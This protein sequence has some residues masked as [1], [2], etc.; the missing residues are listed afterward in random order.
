LSAFPAAPYHPKKL[1][2]K[3]LVGFLFVLIS[4]TS[5]GQTFEANS[6]SL[7]VEVGKQATVL[8]PQDDPMIATLEDLGIKTLP[9]YYALIIGVSEYKY[10]GPRLQSLD[11]PAKDA[12]KLS[13]IL[14]DKY[15]FAREDVKL[16]QNPTAEEIINSFEHL[17]ETVTEKDNVLIFYAGHGSYDQKKGFGYWLPSDAKPDSPS[18]WISNSIIKDYIEAIKS[19]HTLLITDACFSGSIFKSR[20]FDATRKRMTE[21]Y[22]DKSR[23]AMTSGN[24][25]EVPDKSVFIKFLIKTLDENP[26]P[27]IPTSVLFNRMYEPILNNANTTPQFGVVQGA[28]D[29]GGEFLFFKKMK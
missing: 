22:R 16:L 28:G 1:T 17:S 19:K 5:F 25:T 21:M 10:A 3:H 29:E 8:P 20:S 11:L 2:M 12:L 27:Y 26:D 14:I 24:L 15:A 23:K 9:K 13:Q 18:G 6:N 7:A 4:A